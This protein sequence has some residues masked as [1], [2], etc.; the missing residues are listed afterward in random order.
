MV[1]TQ[2]FRVGSL[3]STAAAAERGRN[4]TT[5]GLSPLSVRPS[6]RPPSINSVSEDS[7]YFDIY[8]FED[9]YYAPIDSKYLCRT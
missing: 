3:W 4:A 8:G 2:F 5:D 9:R 1:K 7:E 6:V